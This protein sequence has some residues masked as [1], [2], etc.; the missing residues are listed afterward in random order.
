M[1]AVYLMEEERPSPRDGR[2]KGCGGSVSMACGI[3]LSLLVLWVVSMFVFPAQCRRPV[4]RAISSL[5][6]AIQATQSPTLK[7]HAKGAHK[8][9]DLTA[10]GE[11]K[12]EENTEALKEAEKKT[13]VLLIFAQWCPHCH[14]AMP[15]YI[16][17]S[18]QSDAPFYIVDS[19]CIDPKSIQGE[20]ASFEVTHFPF[21]VKNEVGEDGKR[22]VNVMQEAVTKENIIKFANSKVGSSS[23]S[24][25]GSMFD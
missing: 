10:G 17:A 20:G 23:S 25:M 7:K 22:S 15:G 18:N 13:C 16:E 9:T 19:A 3:L 2:K 6:I 11:K 8:T 24:S 5:K 12:K 4:E 1:N 14:S 21:I